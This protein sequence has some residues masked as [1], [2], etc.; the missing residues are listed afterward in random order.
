MTSVSTSYSDYSDH[1]DYAVE[2]TNRSGTLD[3]VLDDV[4][5]DSITDAVDPDA[6]YRSACA[7]IADTFDQD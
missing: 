6:N 3:K 1:G 2:T 4:A 7:G 5:V